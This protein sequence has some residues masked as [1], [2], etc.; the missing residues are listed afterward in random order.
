MAAYSKRSSSG[1]KCFGEQVSMWIP[2][3]E[4]YGQHLE[5]GA[6]PSPSHPIRRDLP[7]TKKATAA[8]PLLDSR[9]AASA[10]A[11]DACARRRNYTL[12]VLASKEIESFNIPN[13]IVK[14]HDTRAISWT[15]ATADHIRR[16]RASSRRIARRRQCLCAR[17]RRNWR[18]VISGNS[19]ASTKEKKESL[20]FMVICRRCVSFGIEHKAS[21]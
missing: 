2:C 9:A 4:L 15:F 7:A 20:E 12:C 1:S 3:H 5:W 11:G 8:A 6:V 16:R 17:R 14:Y 21:Y 13:I 10:V 18:R 19:A